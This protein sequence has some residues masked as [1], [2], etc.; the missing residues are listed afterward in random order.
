MILLIIAKTQSHLESKTSNKNVK[1][2]RRIMNA[3]M[4][5]LPLHWHKY[6]DDK[7][8]GRLRFSLCLN[9]QLLH[10]LCALWCIVLEFHWMNE[11]KQSVTG[12]RNWNVTFFNRPLNY[13]LSSLFLVMYLLMEIES[14]EKQSNNDSHFVY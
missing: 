6:Y 3:L 11:E 4:K 12:V 14:A 10:I 13:L 1:Q 5:R 2:K 7:F 8:N 9:N